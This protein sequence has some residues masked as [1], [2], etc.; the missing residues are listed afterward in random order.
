M[1]LRTKLMVGVILV[2]NVPL[3]IVGYASLFKSRDMISTQTEKHLVAIREIKKILIEDYF[4]QL[5][6]LIQTRSGALGTISAL[7]TLSESTGEITTELASD[8]GQLASM[9]AAIKAYY[10]RRLATPYRKQTGSKLDLSKYL[11]QTPFGVYAQYQFIETAISNNVAPGDIESPDDMTLYMQAHEQYH[12]DL[13]KFKAQYHL[14]DLY[15]IDRHGVVVYSVNK[16]IDYGADLTHGGLAGS[17]LAKAVMAALKSGKSGS[18]HIA[19]FSRYVPALAKP[20][21]FIATP[22]HDNFS[23]FLGALAFKVNIRKLDALL[24]E[25]PSMGE[26]ERSFLI[27]GDGLTRNDLPGGIKLLQPME[28][29][30]ISGAN[31]SDSGVL[32]AEGDQHE[33]VVGAYA[34]LAIPGLDWKL[35][36]EMKRSEMLAL[37]SPLLYIA[38]LGSLITLVVGQLV[39]NY[40]ARRFDA[41]LGG[42][43]RD[44]SRIAE[45]MAEGDLRLCEEQ[46][47]TRGAAFAMLA[48]KKKISEVIQRVKA[49]S[50][51]LGDE[52]SEIAE[53]NKHLAERIE[54]QSRD[55]DKILDAVDE[56][57]CLVTQS[58]EKTGQVKEHAR[59]ATALAR[60][61]GAVVDESIQAMETISD[62]SR[63]MQG[64]IAV[65]DDLAFQTNLLALNAAVEAAHAGEHGQGFA[66]VAA[67]VRSLAQK[68]GEAAKQ[69]AQLINKSSAMV[70]TGKTHVNHS[71]KKLEN[72]IESF[73]RVDELIDAIFNDSKEQEMRVTEIRDALQRIGDATNSSVAF[74]EQVAKTSQ[75]IEFQ[76]GKLKSAVSFF[77]VQGDALE[78]DNAQDSPCPSGQKERR[79]ASRPWSAPAKNA[80]TKGRQPEERAETVTPSRWAS[81]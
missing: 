72:I 19:D 21:L 43:P 29:A 46:A 50:H 64:I 77:T 75:G 33:P 80:P 39:A 11:P 2:A 61:G 35:F 59:S 49:I 18:V 54:N 55:L 31:A 76:S 12:D 68:S 22:V 78:P 47:P 34:K 13:K 69:I 5:S 52:A 25:L 27:G 53:G 41:E 17:G 9:K 32:T 58:S 7:R 20:A 24:N 48:M 62:A 67:E 23:R 6:T 8:P 14:D 42:D 60:E 70:E 79:A 28:S 10:Q 16:T 73:S 63:E 40:L 4:N 56:I 44:I 81:F 37:S 36:T 74:V 3:A 15:L 45:Q 71:G 38:L 65:I 30:L 57:S 26:T 51:E 1:K 66:V